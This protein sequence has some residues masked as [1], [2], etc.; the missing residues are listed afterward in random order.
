MSKQ[1]RLLSAFNWS[2]GS[3]V[4]V[5]TDWILFT[6]LVTINHPYVALFHGTSLVFQY[7]AIQFSKKT[8]RAVIEFLPDPLEESHKTNIDDLMDKLC[9]PKKE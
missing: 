6:I 7:L 3:I 8:L 2:V 9:D 1:S 4:D 5:V